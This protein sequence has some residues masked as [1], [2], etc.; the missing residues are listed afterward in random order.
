MRRDSNRRSWR[1]LGCL[2]DLLRFTCV[3]QGSQVEPHASPGSI[4]LGL[5]PPLFLAAPLYPLCRSGPLEFK[6]RQQLFCALFLEELCIRVRMFGKFVFL[7]LLLDPIECVAL[8]DEQ[9]FE[10]YQ[11]GLHEIT[12][13]KGP[14][15]LLMKNEY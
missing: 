14:K 8:M 9:Y 12:T 11:L 3:V 13:P 10:D 4:R 15:L 2:E 1:L 5:H 7:E 6:Y